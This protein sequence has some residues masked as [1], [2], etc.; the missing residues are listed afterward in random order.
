MVEKAREV[1]TSAKAAQV[2]SIS[3][4]QL[5]MPWINQHLWTTMSYFVDDVVLSRRMI[6]TQ[7]G[8]WNGLEFWRAMYVEGK[9]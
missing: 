8:D 2:Q 3:G 6:Y 5:D 1:I 9:I 7:G 4:V